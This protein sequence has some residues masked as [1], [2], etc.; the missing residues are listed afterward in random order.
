MAESPESSTFTSAFDRIKAAQ[1]KTI[2]S[3]AA[4]MQT[5]NREEASKILKSSTPEQLAERRKA[6]KS[7]RGPR[8][9]RDGWLAPLALNPRVTGPA[10]NK[11][12]VRAS[13]KGFL[14]MSLE[15]YIALL[16]WTGRQ[17]REDKNGKITADHA[18]ILAKLGIAEGMWCDLVWNFKRYFG[19][20]RGPGSPDRMRE[21][22]V[23]GMR[24]FQPGQKKV[25][26]CFA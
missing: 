9:V 3:A 15:D 14:D 17:G 2:E 24:K 11:D 25:R 7:R 23:L 10:V 18:P 4:S 26:E 16:Y 21:E 19:R 5:I 8:I 22:A 6:A 12:G 1:G 20:S 13:D